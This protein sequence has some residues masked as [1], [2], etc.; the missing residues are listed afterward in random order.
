MK[1]EKTIY[2][3]IG[4]PKTGTTTL[5]KY[6]FPKHSGIRSLQSKDELNFMQDVFYSRENSLKRKDRKSTR[7]NSSHIPL[8]RMPSSA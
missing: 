8:S 5:Q 2:L 4:Y 3:H 7:L 6:L 1:Q